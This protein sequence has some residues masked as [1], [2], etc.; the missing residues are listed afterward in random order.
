MPLGLSIE[1]SELE[2]SRYVAPHQVHSTMQ[3]PL[4]WEGVLVRGK[5]TL[6]SRVFVRVKARLTVSLVEL[7]RERCELFVQV[8]SWCGGKDV[9]QK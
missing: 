6:A 4:C 8:L 7:K 1:L 2:K 5:M 9:L 3:I